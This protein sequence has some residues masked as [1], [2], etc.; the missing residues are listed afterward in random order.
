MHTSAC[1]ACTC[2][3]FLFMRFF[4]G[5][6][7]V[8]LSSSTVVSINPFSYGLF[9]AFPVPLSSLFVTCGS[10]ERPLAVEVSAFAVIVNHPISRSVC[11]AICERC[12]YMNIIDRLV[13]GKELLQLSDLVADENRIRDSDNQVCLG[14]AIWESSCAAV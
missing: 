6:C 3:Y 1:I 2:L 5:A 11:V 9:F 13:D 7:G 14:G 8:L 12:L 4:L 10:V